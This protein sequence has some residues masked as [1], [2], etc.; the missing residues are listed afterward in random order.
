MEYYLIKGYTTP[1]A[2]ILSSN[3]GIRARE[4]Q[5]PELPTHI[6]PRRGDSPLLG[7][8][9]TMPIVLKFKYHAN[10][11]FGMIQRGPIGLFQTFADVGVYYPLGEMWESISP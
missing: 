7:L 5:E 3:A 4:S 6:R 1:C 10:L 9:Y 11:Q 8:S 2:D